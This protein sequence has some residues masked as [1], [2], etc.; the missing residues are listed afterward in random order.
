MKKIETTLAIAACLAVCSSVF[1][2]SSNPDPDPDPTNKTSSPFKGNK[3]AMSAVTGVALAGEMAVAYKLFTTSLEISGA[4]REYLSTLEKEAFRISEEMKKVS[5]TDILAN[6]EHEAIPVINYTWGNSGYQDVP[7]VVN[8]PGA[9]Q[10]KINRGEYFAT[11]I[12]KDAAYKKI[13]QEFAEATD[14]V[15]KV[16]LSYLGKMTI[17][18]RGIRFARWAGGIALLVDVSQKAYFWASTGE[19]PSPIPFSGAVTALFK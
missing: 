5:G 2:G 3:G 4:E 12:E 9:A 13:G 16:K 1:A 6:L 18:K 10:A 17:L 8:H 11:A 7:V 15:V 19:P 14:K